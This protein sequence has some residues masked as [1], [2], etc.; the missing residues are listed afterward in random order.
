[1]TKEITLTIDGQQI[2]VPDGTLVVD[3]AKRAGIDIPV[4]C[5]HPKMEPVGMCRMCLVDVGRPV[6]DRATGEA[7][8]E[9]DGSPKIQFGWKLETACT[10]PVS[11]GMVVDGLSDKVQQGREDIVE[12]LLTSHPL[13]CPICDKGGECPLQNL[14]MEYGSSDSRFIFDEKMHAAKNVPLGDLIWLDR[15]RCIQCARCIRFQEEI[16]DD[17]VLE[18]FNRGRATDIITNSEPGFASYW[19]GNT[20]DI[21]P[22]GA[23]TT[24][25]FRFGARPWEL[26]Q[27]ASLCNHCAVGCNLTYNTRRDAKSGGDIIIKRAMPRQNEQVNELWICD[28]GRFAYHYVNSSDRLTQPLI[29]KDGQLSPASWEEALTLVAEQLKNAG[30]GLLTLA[31]GR[32]PNEDLFNLKKLSEGLGGTAALHS[33][34]AG[35]DLVAQMG[36]SDTVNLSTVGAG[37]AIVVVASD[38]EEE[39]PVWWLRAK[40]AAKRGA[41]LIVVNPRP[42]KTERHATEIIRYVYGEEVAAIEKVDLDDAKKVVAF[43]GSEGLGLEGSAAVAQACAK[44][45]AG[46]GALVGVWPQANT[47]GA[48][49]MGLR[50]GADLSSAKAFYIAGADPVGDNPALAEI[51]Q[52]ADFVVVQELFLTETAALADVVLPAQAQQE[53]EGTFTSGERRV[54]RF[55]PVVSSKGECKADFAIA[56]KIGA[57]AGVDLK[58]RF[59]SLIF[60][61]ICAEVAGYAGLSYAKLAEVNEQWPIVS[62]GDLFY[63]GTSYENKQ[64][65]GVQL[66]PLGVEH[67]STAAATPATVLQAA[68]VAVPITRLY[69]QGKLVGASDVLQPR[70]AQPFVLVNPEDSQKLKSTDG[71]AVSLS[72][73]GSPAIDVVVREDDSVPQG[74]ALVP[75]SMGIPIEQ[76]SEFTF[77]IAE[78]AVA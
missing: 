73:N 75:R 48:W 68:F 41:K 77:G 30:A 24:A 63:G 35:G 61:Q 70:L 49:D 8:L 57:K 25:D 69:D 36:I 50:P 54:Q 58:G 27:A 42:T 31:G 78:S 10:V 14:T 65:L 56:A 37:D 5:Y 60:P 13:D 46:K 45:A 23:L 47:Q 22:V 21:C 55:Y 33:Y 16:A 1:M 15:E 17:P 44:L 76:P 59:P 29:R 40:Q 43:F 67:T 74:F 4:F 9:E 7:V 34:M 32:L 2:T 26:N 66:A 62:R 72:V 28:K 71:M 52:R 11:E 19:S 64:G 51:V 12:F 3:A 39:A 38:L 18:F 53:R 6:F 20:T